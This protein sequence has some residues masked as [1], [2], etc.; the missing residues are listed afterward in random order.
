MTRRSASDHRESFSVKVAVAKLWS[1]L[2]CCRDRRRPARP[3]RDDRKPFVAAATAAAATA[4]LGEPQ[5]YI[6][7]A[8]ASSL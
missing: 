1:V 4:A 7:D 5:R 2:N 3:I 8:I 6:T